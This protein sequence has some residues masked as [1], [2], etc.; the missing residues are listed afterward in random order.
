MSPPGGQY[1]MAQNAVVAQNS[2]ALQQQQNIHDDVMQKRRQ[3]HEL[4]MKKLDLKKDSAPSSELASA[5]EV[6][7][8][9]RVGWHV[10]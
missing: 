6:N 3:A 5:R 1:M 7:K 2:L 4:E 9:R 10:L 8:L